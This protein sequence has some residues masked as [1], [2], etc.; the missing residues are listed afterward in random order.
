MPVTGSL[1]APGSKGVIYYGPSPFPVQ[2]PA[3]GWPG[4]GGEKMTEARAWSLLTLAA[5]LLLG[6]AYLT[7]GN[8]YS[9]LH[10]RVQKEYYECAWGVKGC[11]RDGNK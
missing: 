10:R 8:H 1:P 11:Q 3:G 6:G 7:R 9:H 4:S 5:V 2:P